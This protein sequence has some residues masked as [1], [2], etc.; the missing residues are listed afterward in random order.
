MYGKDNEA[1]NGNVM[2]LRAR[3]RKDDFDKTADVAEVP[4]KLLGQT[5]QTDHLSQ[6]TIKTMNGVDPQS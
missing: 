4:L 3:N 2:D 1:S 5:I 6:P